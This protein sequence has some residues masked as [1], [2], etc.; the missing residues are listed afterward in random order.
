MDI[1]GASG[2]LDFDPTTEETTA[3]VDVWRIVPSTGDDPWEFLET[4]CWDF[5]ETPGS[6][7][8]TPPPNGDDDDDD[9]DE[10]N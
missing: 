10:R 1:D 4:H 3:P 7:D 2:A 8:G 5:S 9:D 6:C